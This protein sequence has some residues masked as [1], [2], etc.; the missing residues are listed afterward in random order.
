MS[1]AASACAIAIRRAGPPDAP[2]IA[3]L[4]G[5]SFAEP[6]DAHSMAEFLGSPSCLCLIASP[7]DDAPPQAFLIARKAGDEAEIITI[8]AAPE[9]RR[10]GVARALVQAAMAD[11]RGAGAAKLFLE[12]EEGNGAARG[13]YASLGAIPVG[14]R[15]AYYRNGADALIFC[16]AL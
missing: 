9:C 5:A 6:W 15:P 12:V 7:R 13:L 4:H 14:R 16:L 3:A 8:A 11:L 2:A 10:Q 1:T